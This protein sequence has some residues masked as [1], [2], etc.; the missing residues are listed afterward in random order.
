ME[1]FIDSADLSE[2][3]T[4]IDQGVI[5]GVTTNPSILLKDRV[6]DIESGIKT[7]AEAIGDRPLSV[8]VTTDNQEEMLVQAREFASWAENI[9]VKIPVINQYGH[10]C[11]GVISALARENIKVNVT[12]ILSY[13]Q[14]VLAAKAGGTYLS[15][16]AGRVCDEGHDGAELISNSVRFTEKWGFGKILAGS[17]RGAFDVQTAATAGAHIVT[18]P[19]QFLN[20]MVDHKYTRETIKEF[21]NNAEQAMEEIGRLS[22]N[23]TDIFPDRKEI[24]Q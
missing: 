11:L 14:I 10:P 6:F 23:V 24:A 4:W 22:G 3:E 1:I 12:G 16:F 17:I 15:I 8:E 19:P 5:D 7:I 9:V 20:K 2:I 21:I 13:N 18:V